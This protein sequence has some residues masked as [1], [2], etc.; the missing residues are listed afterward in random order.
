V[1]PAGDRALVA[2]KQFLA[3][4]A[5]A[6]AR[7][8]LAPAGIEPIVLKGAHLGHTFYSDPREREYCDL[9]LLVRKEHFEEAA[10]L[11][12]GAGFRPPVLEGRRALT[13]RSFYCWPFDAPNGTVIELHRELAGHGRYPVESAALFDRAVPFRFGAEP[14]RGLGLEDLLLHLSIH[15]AKSYFRN[16]EEKHIRDLDTILRKAAPDWDAFVARARVAGCAAGAYWGLRAAQAQYGTPLPPGVLASLRPG[17]LRRMWLWGFLNPA[18]TPCYR[19]GHH[20]TWLVQALVALPLVDP[21][22]R[23]PEILTRY[24]RLRGGEIALALS[25][26]SPG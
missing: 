1:P 20:P 9:D 11:L 24:L 14:A 6:Q 15:L 22:R 26:R 18:K 21:V 23:W 2:R 3:E 4:L 25:G 7:D 16:I 8:A 17:R 12:A 5:F 19:W 13:L 10:R